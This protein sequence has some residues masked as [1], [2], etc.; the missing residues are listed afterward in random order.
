MDEVRRSTTTGRALEDWDLAGG[1]AL[2]LAVVLIFPDPFTSGGRGAAILVVA[3][4]VAIVI[5]AG[6]SIVDFLTFGATVTGPRSLD[7][8]AK[9]RTAATIFVVGD[10]VGI[11]VV[12][13]EWHRILV[14]QAT[15]RLNCS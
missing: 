6:I 1:A 8:T 11:G 13:I 10:A 2:P 5:G 12:G 14:G 3:D 9:R 7:V 4:T 15:I